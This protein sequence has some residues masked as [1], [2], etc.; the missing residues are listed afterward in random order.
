MGLAEGGHNARHLLDRP[1]GFKTMNLLA[2]RTPEAPDKDANVS[3]NQPE[4]L[5][6]NAEQVRNDV[7]VGS[8]DARVAR[9]RLGARPTDVGGELL[10]RDYKREDGRVVGQDGSLGGSEHECHHHKALAVPEEAKALHQK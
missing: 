6:D 4:W 7:S 10:A 2:R 3:I 1:S 5:R 9:E 8:G